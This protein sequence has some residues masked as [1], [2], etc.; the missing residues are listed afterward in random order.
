MSIKISND[1]KNQGG[2]PAQLQGIDG[3]QPA[4]GQTGRIY[5][6]TDTNIIY[7]D[8]GTAWV[9]FTAAAS[10]T[11][12]GV[13]GTA[14]I[15]VATGTTT[16]V[17]S[18]T[19]A[20]AVNE[21]YVTTGT[22]TL[23]GSK[24]FEGVTLSSISMVGGG[25]YASYSAGVNYLYSGTANA[26]ITNNTGATTLVAVANATGN[27]TV[28]GTVTS[29]T[30]IGALTGNAS[31]V[32]T[33][34]NLTGVITSVGNATSIASQT[35]TGSTFAMNTSPTLV[36]PVL[37][38]A[39]GG[40]LGLSGALTGTSAT[41][42]GNVGIGTTLSAWGSAFN[43]SVIEFAG[44]GSLLGQNGTPA[45]YIGTNNL[46]NT[47][48]NF[49]RKIDGTA[50]QYR[51][52]LGEHLFQS[53]VSGSAGTTITLI[54]RLIIAA[55]GNVGIGTTSPSYT[56]HVN[57]SVAGTSATF[58]GA[59]SAANLASGRYTP[60]KTGI[61]NVTSSTGTDWSYTRIGDQV[62]VFGVVSV[63]P[64]LY[65]STSTEI[66]FSLPIGSNLAF[67]GD[68]I[69]VI[70]GAENGS[71]TGAVLQGSSVN[72]RAALTYSATASVTSISMSFSYTVL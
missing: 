62:R 50:A 17:I 61:T 32:T 54:D 18:M 64:T 58:S 27:T 19:A 59:V 44:G 55:N 63:T 69:G 12:T 2:A 5:W 38:N 24:T 25:A 35:G 30:F 33:N 26:I 7:R 48:D 15:S 65:A 57:G 43:G 9:V 6:A 47:S 3:A 28:L 70:S 11:V 66:Q 1:I 53:A 31:T 60:T 20:S 52:Y 34:A 14:P 67:V 49:V 21:G 13:T 42:S 10:G 37:G 72:D 8:S 45:M 51:Q 16:P 22:Q 56:L 71:Y 68:L 39:T 23:A 4:A 46:Y 41:F 40:T 29:P 36:T